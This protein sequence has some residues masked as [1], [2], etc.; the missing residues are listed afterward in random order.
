[1]T[2]EE[3]TATWAEKYPRPSESTTINTAFQLRH[4]GRWF[5]LKEIRDITRA[6]FR[7]FARQFPGAAR[8]ARTALNDAID[9]GLLEENPASKCKVPAP[10]TKEVA[11]P[12]RIEIETLV[13][14]ARAINNDF[15]CMVEFCAY[16]GLREGEARALKTLCVATDIWRGWVQW[17]MDRNGNLKE[18]KTPQSKAEFGIL[19][20]ARPAL[21]K[22]GERRQG[23]FLFP[24]TYPQRA[25]YWRK[26][27]EVTGLDFKWH[28]L[29]HF[30]AT[31]L[32]NRGATV[33]DVAL[34][35]RCSVDEIRRTYGKPDR[36]AA[37]DRLAA[38]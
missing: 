11:V 28:A 13:I 22:L 10:K 20:R 6:D 23:E 8:Y 2:A 34:Q 3:L 36:G 33:D 18:P 19:N 27:R 32:L 31:D 29:R 4:F 1:M 16:T 25:D 12:T 35:L 5:G 21:E 17:S 15:G 26:T 9:D 14:H 37:L 38:L 30:C 7:E 24:F